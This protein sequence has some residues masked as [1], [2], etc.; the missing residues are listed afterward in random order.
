MTTVR[1]TR[2]AGVVLLLVLLAVGV[3]LAWFAVQNANRYWE[4][5]HPPEGAELTSATVTAVDTEDFC[6]R[7]SKS[8]TRCVTEV[9]GL[10]I[11]VADGASH[12]VPAHAVFSPGDEVEAFQDGDGDW[13]VKGAFT[14]GWAVRTVGATGIG[15][16]AI[17][18]LVGASLRPRRVSAEAP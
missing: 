15:A 6:G 11:R 16:L 9:D 5:N 14:K 17:L 3:L 2:I 7:T 4:A 18:L 1:G 13:Q 12:H 10:D 8:S